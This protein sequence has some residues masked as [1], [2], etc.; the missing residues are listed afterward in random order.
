M[1]PPIL[2][3]ANERRG[4]PKERRRPA[5]VR[6]APE[7]R[8]RLRL[9]GRVEPARA[10]TS[11]RRAAELLVRKTSNVQ[12]KGK[13]K[14]DARCQSQTTPHPS[15]LESDKFKP[16]LDRPVT[17]SASPVVLPAGLSAADWWWWRP[18]AG[19]PCGT[20]HPELHWPA[21]PRRGQRPFLPNSS[22]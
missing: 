9:V 6:R 1:A 7:R 4:R 17:R 3:P 14:A 19:W 8:R 2:S 18:P 22:R 12:R 10:Q 21:W 13:G 20:P 16:G 5:C 15:P 11:V